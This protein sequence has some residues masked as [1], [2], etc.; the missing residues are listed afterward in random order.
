LNLLA[1]ATDLILITSIPTIAVPKIVNL[2]FLEGCMKFCFAKMTFREITTKDILALFD[3]RTSVRENT[4]SRDGL[5]RD[6]ITEETVAEMI[7]TTHRGWLC[8]ANSKIV[9]F[10]MAN[11]TT[12]EFSVMAVL[13]EYEVQ[14][15]GSKLLLLAEAWLWAMGWEEI[16]LQTSLNTRLKA[17]SFYRNR[18]WTDAE[19]RTNQRI[20]KKRRRD[21]CLRTL[22][23]SLSSELMQNLGVR[24]LSPIVRTALVKAPGRTDWA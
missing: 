11:G 20:M 9:G 23:R 14:G 10:A 24:Y 12:G 21:C 4:Y 19:I 5:Y 22:V 3:V 7:G 17:Y 15:I 18:G 8:E 2:R 16:W 1:P 13:P 6:G